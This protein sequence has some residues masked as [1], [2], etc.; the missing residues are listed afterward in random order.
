MNI[1]QGTSKDEAERR[2]LVRISLLG[3]ASSWLTAPLELRETLQRVTRLMVPALADACVVQLLGRGLASAPEHTRPQLEELVVAHVDG[4]VE[5]RIRALTPDWGAW[6]HRTHGAREVVRTG[7]LQLVSNLASE[8]DDESEPSLMRELAASVYIALP[9][10]ARGQ[11]IGVLSFVHCTSTRAAFDAQLLSELAQR[12]SG[13]IDNARLYEE[14]QR[15]I[16]VRDDL[17][18]VVSHDL[19]SP[20]N[21]IGMTVKSL[22]KDPALTADASVLRSLALIERTS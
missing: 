21:A 19:Q 9:L 14:A 20:V 1:E 8:P 3:E 4:A 7:Q 2:A 11:L 15:A 13:A 22:L 6:L 17:L 18:A 5:R 10:H 16:A 12:A